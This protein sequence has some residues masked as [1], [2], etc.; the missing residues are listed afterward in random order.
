[1]WCLAGGSGCPTEEGVKDI[2]KAAKVKALKASPEKSLG[3]TMPKAVIGSSL[4]RVR[5]HFVG[6]VDL[7]ESFPRPILLIVVRVILKGQLTKRPPYFLLGGIS[8][9]AEDLIII[10]LGWH[11]IKTLSPY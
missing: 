2:A 6:F 10:S 8:I 11:L 9:Y 7:F 4:I 3:T 1:M 5:E